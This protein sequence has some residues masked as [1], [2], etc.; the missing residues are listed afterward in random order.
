M[1]TSEHDEKSA[2]AAGIMQY[3]YI[4][5]MVTENYVVIIWKKTH[6]LSFPSILKYACDD[7]NYLGPDSI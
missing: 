7:E 2:C 5:D 6:D 4:K 1:F 3:S